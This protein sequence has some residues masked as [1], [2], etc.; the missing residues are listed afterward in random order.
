MHELS[1]LAAAVEAPSRDCMIAEGRVWSYAHTAKRVRAAIS[2]LRDRGVV[3]R[4]RVAL[5][6]NLDADSLIW[7]YA[8]FELGCPA[9]LLHPRLT[10]R[11]REQLL[12]EAQPAHLITERSTD[13]AAVEEAWFPEPIDARETLAIAYTSGSTGRPRGAQLSRRAFIASEAAHAAN[14]GWAPEDRW[15]LCMTPAH[16]GGLSIVTRCLIARKCVV[17]SRGAFDSATAIRTMA[18][19]RV[20]LASLVPTMLR[21]LLRTEDPRW[22]PGSDLRAVL[23]GGAQLPDTLRA[24]ALER[25]VPILA[26]YGCTEACSQLST[27]SPEQRGRPGS[28]APLP[29]VQVR[30]EEGEIQ[31]RGEVLMD[32][33]FGEAH[34]AAPWTPDGWLRTGDLGW[35][36]PDGQLHIRGR[37]DDLIVTGGENVSPQE[38]ESWLESVPGIEAACVF[39]LPHEDWGQEV[40]AALVTDATRYD[41]GIL[42]ARLVR[43]LAPHKRPKR[44]CALDGFPS[45]RSGK[46]DRAA[47]VALCSGQLRPI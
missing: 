38:V 23:V 40:V 8:L 9:V 10:E 43:E 27:Q 1:V 13:E 28:G 14:L 32:G 41:A 19:D 45:N 4:D 30:V 22:T 3:P 35:F 24:L 47:V 2:M 5:T 20:T 39:S 17:L 46:L 36:S 44:I 7:L 18:E 15:L 26:T 12:Q 11:E 42:R 25:G 6:P 31:V 37:I 34:D 16:I 21:R 29:G 33:Y